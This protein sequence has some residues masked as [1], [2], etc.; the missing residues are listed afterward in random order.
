VTNWAS[1]AQNREA[2]LHF[3]AGAVPARSRVSF[4]ANAGGNTGHAKPSLLHR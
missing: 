4:G 3:A 2:T 1:S